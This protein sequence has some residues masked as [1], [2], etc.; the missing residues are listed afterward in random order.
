MEDMDLASIVLGGLDRCHNVVYGKQCMSW[1]K[2]AI[3]ASGQDFVYQVIIRNYENPDLF[4]ECPGLRFDGGKVCPMDCMKYVIENK[5]E[6][7][8]DNY[9]VMVA[10]GYS[11]FVLINCH[12]L[13][14]YQYEC[15]C[16]F[17]ERYDIELFTTTDAIVGAGM[18]NLWAH[19]YVPMTHGAHGDIPCLW[20]VDEDP[21]AQ[22]SIT[23]IIDTSLLD[24]YEDVFQKFVELT[25]GDDISQYR[26]FVVKN[27]GKEVRVIFNKSFCAY[28]GRMTNAYY[29]RPV[30]AALHYTDDMSPYASDHIKKYLRQVEGMNPIIPVESKSNPTEDITSGY[31]SV[32]DPKDKPPDDP[33]AFLMWAASKGGN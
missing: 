24:S 31:V 26:H 2:G 19:V 18:F 1:G 13:D 25:Q 17:A 28:A 4:K 23:G 7:L 22:C 30:V 33:M 29:I 20:V 21:F 8:F 11:Q 3:G 9:I 6:H 10:P 27:S 32:E 12:E 16:K 5:A 15:V 14:I